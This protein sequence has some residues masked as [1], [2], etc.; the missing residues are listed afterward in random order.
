MW[1][2]APRTPEVRKMRGPSEV[3]RTLVPAG[4]RLVSTLVPRLTTS[5]EMSLGAA[6]TSVRATS[7]A[8]VFSSTSLNMPATHSL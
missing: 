5:A 6:D 8:H 7:R 4:S 2:S 1:T 3:A